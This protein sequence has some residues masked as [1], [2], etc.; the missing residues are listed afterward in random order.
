MKGTPR[1]STPA[2]L[3]GAV[4][5]AGIAAGCA[6]AIRLSPSIPQ[7]VPTT[8][9]DD[10]VAVYISPFFQR[11]VHTQTLDGPGTVDIEIGP[12]LVSGARQSLQAF[13]NTV[14]ILGPGETS[15]L[16]YRIDIRN[17]RFRFEDD[18]GANVTIWCKVTHQG[19]VLLEESFDGHG[20]G[21]T[22]PG[23][24]RLESAREEIRRAG[25]AAF[26]D[27]YTKLQKAFFEKAARR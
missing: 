19:K 26:R 21:S 23:F 24:R 1:F 14:M 17:D 25:E 4:L 27:A 20:P 3:L 9:L 18:F 11:Q 10:Q 13:F 7:A 22:E 2:I 15:S 8:R 12:A 16:P 5:L 6:S